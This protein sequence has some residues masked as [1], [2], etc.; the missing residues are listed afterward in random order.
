MSAQDALGKRMT[1]AREDCGMSVTAAARRMAVK[2]ATLRSWEE[3]KTIPRANKL[4]LLAGILSVPVTWLMDG[5]ENIAFA[6]AD[7]WTRLERL[8]LKMQRMVK[9]QNEMIELSTEVAEELAS[10][11]RIDEELEALAA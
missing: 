10:L 4:H 2:P 9:L 3:G 11:R 7:R 6:A 5:D 8:E 1:E